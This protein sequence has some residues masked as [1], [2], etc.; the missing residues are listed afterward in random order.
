MYVPGA[1]MGTNAVL[2]GN[3]IG[4]VDDL[5]VAQGGVISVGAGSLVGGTTAAARNIISGLWITGDNVT[6]RGNHFGFNDTGTNAYST[7]AQSIEVRTRNWGEVGPSNVTIGGLTTGSRNLFAGHVDINPGTS[8]LLFQGNYLGVDTTGKVAVYPSGNGYPGLTVAGTNHTIGGASTA[9][10]NLIAASGSSTPTS[11]VR[12]GLGVSDMTNYGTSNILI[13]GNY[14]GTDDTGSAQLGG[15][16]YGVIVQGLA[17]TVSIGGTST[18]AGNVISGMKNAGIS[19]E[20]ADLGN[21]TKMSPHDNIIQGNY[22]GTDK[23]GTA[24]IPNRWGVAIKNSW[25]NLIGGTEAGARN[26]ISGNSEAGILVWSGYANSKWNTIQGNY[27]GVDATGLMKLANTNWGMYIDGAENVIGGLT[28][29]ARNVVSGNGGRGIHVM[30]SNQLVQGNYVGIGTDGSTAIGNGI[31]IQMDGNGNTVGGTTASARNVVAANTGGGILVQGSGQTVQG[32]YVGVAANGTTPLGNLYGVKVFGFNSRIG[33]ETAGAPNLIVNSSEQGVVVTGGTGNSIQRNSIYGNSMGID[34]GNNGVTPNDPLDADTGPNNLQNA[35]VL[36]SIETATGFTVNGA[37]HSMPSK[38]YLLEF[39]AN[40][41]LDSGNQGEGQ[42]FLGSR[43][44]TTNSM[45][46]VTFSTTFPAPSCP[47]ITANATDPDGNTSEFSMWIQSSVTLTTT[48]SPQGGG[49][50]TPDCSA[51]C[52]Y[53]MGQTVTLTPTPAYGRTFSSWS[54]DVNSI[55][56][57][58]TFTINGP[59]KI[60][61]NFDSTPV[62]GPLRIAGTPPAYYTTV[63]QALASAGNNDVIQMQATAY[64]GALTFDNPAASVTLK[65]GYNSSYSGITGQTVLGSPFTIKSGSVIVDNI[66]IN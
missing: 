25:D 39:F 42:T 28:D 40:C 6:V 22:I 48:I 32:N 51:G 21:G 60:T 59:K 43:D 4:V 11:A 47:I 50:V 23:N 57:P 9:A 49:T 14:I 1:T 2:E 52:T 61:V 33:G 10:R 17:N 63:A 34:L 31:G 15:W 20:E 66:V 36:T 27:I 46:D 16:G 44:V 64:D 7:G 19:I 30:G 29:A 55:N 62:T 53:N 45:G 18:G 54:G 35:P 56:T 38:A 12:V 58:L 3:R 41:A 5:S 65:G 37:L 24:A 26:V 13:Q 8:G